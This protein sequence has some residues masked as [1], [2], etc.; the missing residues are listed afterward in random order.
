MDTSYEDKM[1]RQIEKSLSNN[2][3]D[4]LYVPIEM[5]D[6]PTYR[7]RNNKQIVDSV[8]YDENLL[9]K[10]PAFL[11]NYKYYGNR[12]AANKAIDEDKGATNKPIDEYKG[13][14]NRAIDE[15]KEGL[16]RL[17]RAEYIRQAR[18]ACLRQM[19]QVEAAVNIYDSNGRVDD[20][21]Y[22]SHGRKN[23]DRIEKLFN[24]NEMELPEELASF[25]FLI[26]RT[27]CAAVIFLSIFIV[28]K[29]K[30]SWGAFSYETI[31]QYVT[32]NNQLRA[33]EE[34]IVSWLKQ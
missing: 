18:E 5:I 26:I 32:G 15:D 33:L 17:S 34:I 23:K 8:S 11:D 19:N 22:S 7:G 24:E 20:S 30:V 10:E 4:K 12:G 1:Y 16:P 21:I 28:D 2:I 31:R 27:I 13:A 3:N 6:K 14:S 29:V 9:Q 25:R